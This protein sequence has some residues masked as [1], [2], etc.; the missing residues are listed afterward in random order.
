M[1]K[2]PQHV[3]ANGTLRF[4]PPS[5]MMQNIDL[6][7]FDQQLRTI[8]GILADMQDGKGPLAQFIVNDDLYRQFLDGV[9]KL[10][11]QMHVATG[12]QTELGQ[13]MY[14]TT[15]HDSVLASFKQLDDKL[16]QVQANPLFRN[17]AQYDQIRDQLAQIRKTIGDLNAGKGSGGEFLTS[18]EQYTA[19]NKMLAGWIGNVDSLASGEGSMGQMISNAQTYESLNGK[20]RELE[21]TMK[22]FRAD[23]RKFLR[24]KVF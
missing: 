8:D 18:D 10:E 24:I 6:R 11:K 15:M 5:S 19:W 4:P 7:Q 22:E 3:R 21:T 20:M 9:Q 16:A 12:V 23:P 2:S 14:R 1:G 17:T 13:A